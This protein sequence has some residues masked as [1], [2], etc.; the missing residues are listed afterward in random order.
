MTAMGCLRSKRTACCLDKVPGQGRPL[1]DLY[2]GPYQPS[3]SESNVNIISD[4]MIH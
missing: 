1:R 4:N 2:R 3:E